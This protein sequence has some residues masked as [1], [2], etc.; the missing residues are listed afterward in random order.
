MVSGAGGRYRQVNFSAFANYALGKNNGLRLKYG[1]DW[2]VAE[3]WTWEGW[4]YAD[5]T[6]VTIPSK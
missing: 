1:Y 6:T 2:T 5:G 4:T 3:D